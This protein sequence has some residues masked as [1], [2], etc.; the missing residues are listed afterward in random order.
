MH[1]KRERERDTY[2]YIYIYMIN[3][4]KGMT[5]KD[6]SIHENTVED[7]TSH[8]TVQ[9]RSRRLPACNTFSCTMRVPPHS[10]DPPMVDHGVGAGICIHIYIYIESVTQYRPVFFE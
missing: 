6:F 10:P 7:T 4:P 9:H 8:S 2:I 5:F 1:T 3:P